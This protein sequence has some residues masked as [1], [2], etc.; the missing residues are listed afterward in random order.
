VGKILDPRLRTDPAA[1]LSKT[2]N[3]EIVA[4]DRTNGIGEVLCNYETGLFT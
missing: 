4:N 2:T 3:F 1:S